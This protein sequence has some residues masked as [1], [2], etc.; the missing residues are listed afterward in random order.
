MSLCIPW[1][2]YNAWESARLRLVEQI[3]ARLASGLAIKQTLR[4]GEPLHALETLQHF[5][6]CSP[7]L[8]RVDPGT[9]GFW[10]RY[11]Q[12]LRLGEPLHAFETFSVLGIMFAFAWSSRFWHVWLLVSPYVGFETW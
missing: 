7:S 1:K 9:L 5:R 6:V 4:L 11:K 10:S 3:L 12:A 2:F 8:G